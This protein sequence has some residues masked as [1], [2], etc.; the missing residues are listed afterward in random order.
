VDDIVVALGGKSVRT[1][2]DELE[3][4]VGELH[5]IGDAV[6]PRRIIYATRDGNRVG[7]EL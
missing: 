2:Y 6:A 7:R 4:K 5:L 3:G 1:L